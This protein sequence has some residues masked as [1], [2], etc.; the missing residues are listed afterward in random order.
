[1]N[2]KHALIG[3]AVVVMLAI[4]GWIWLGSSA[5][6]SAPD[7]ELLTTTGSKLRL[8]ALRNRP[9]LVTFWAT[10]CSSCIAELPELKALYRKLSPRGLEVIGIAVYYDPPVQ[11]MDMVKQREIP[12]PVAFDLDRSAMHAFG[13]RRAITPTSFLIAP[14]GRIVMRK[15][16]VL[17]MQTVEQTIRSMLPAA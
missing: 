11:V 9:V 16:G 4:T 15:S 10:T 2:A 5:T 3:A 17:D 7:V 6:A 12:Y 13:L 8:S 14:D 1:M